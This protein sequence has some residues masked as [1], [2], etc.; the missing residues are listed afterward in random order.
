MTFPYKSIGDFDYVL[1]LLLDEKEKPVCYYREHISN[2]TDP[3]AK[4]R[5]I[6][7]KPDPVVGLVK[8]V[9]AAGIISFKMS[10]TDNIDFDFKQYKAWKRAIPMRDHSV[11][12]R[13]YIYQCRDLPSA[14]GDGSA[15]PYLT[16]WDMTQN[17]P[18]KPTKKTPTVFDTVDPLFF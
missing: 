7:L 9:N 11:I 16:V 14:D 1:I 13:C 10:I 17:D 8:D 3:E 4:Y 5:W 6:F 18:K 12:V 2:F 15:D